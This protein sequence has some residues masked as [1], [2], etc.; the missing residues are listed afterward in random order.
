MDFVVKTETVTASKKSN[1]PC[2][3]VCIQGSATHADLTNTCLLVIH[4]P[5]QLLQGKSHVYDFL[6][7]VNL[8]ISK[9][10]NRVDSVFLQ[11]NATPEQM[12]YLMKS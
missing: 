8:T 9:L 11:L 12:L 1:E 2:M 6:W 5:Y 10:S 4:Q 3:F 7:N